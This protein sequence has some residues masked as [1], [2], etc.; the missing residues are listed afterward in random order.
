MAEDVFW[1]V[2]CNEVHILLSWHVYTAYK[3]YS[4]WFFAIKIQCSDLISTQTMFYT[5]FMLLLPFLPIYYFW[6]CIKNDKNVILCDLDDH[7]A[8]RIGHVHVIPS[9]WHGIA[10]HKLCNWPIHQKQFATCNWPY[11]THI[12]R[13][14]VGFLAQKNG[15]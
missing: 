1:L 9:S 3:F 13:D 4:S 2:I 11:Q 15:R 10:S 6:L 12:K 5:H 8:K 7:I 14:L